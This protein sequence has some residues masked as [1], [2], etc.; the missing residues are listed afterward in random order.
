[1]SLGLMRGWLMIKEVKSYFWGVLADLAF[2]LYWYSEK[3]PEQ[4]FKLYQYLGAKGHTE[5]K[6]D[7]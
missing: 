3:L 5:E 1:M 7:L 6:E 4:T 2:T